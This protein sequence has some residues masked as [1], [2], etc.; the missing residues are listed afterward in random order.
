MLV[1]VQALDQWIHECMF[2]CERQVSGFVSACLC[3][4]VELV[5]SLVYLGVWV[6][7]QWIRECLFVCGRQ[8]SGFVSA[9]LCVSVRLVDSCVYL[10]V[11]ALDL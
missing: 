9:C 8:I 2:V 1:C 7:D 10:C 6:L 5:D 4:G 3:V 11:W